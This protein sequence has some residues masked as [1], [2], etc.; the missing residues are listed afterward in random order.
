VL[1]G[2]T[3]G[4][5]FASGMAATSTVMELLDAGSHVVATDDLYGGSFRLFER[6]RRRTAGLDFSFVDLTDPAAFEAAIRPTTKMV[7][8]ETPTNPML[9]LVD[10]AAIAAIARKYGLL[11]VVDNTFASP[12]L[13]R[14]LEL[15]A[16]LV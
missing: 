7:W 11:V 3:R 16:D 15:G 8:I 1:E 14:P 9:K 6:V 4:F 13:Q 5:A 10:I 12:M 2:G